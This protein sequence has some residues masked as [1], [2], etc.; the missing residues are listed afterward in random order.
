MHE[1]ISSTYIK[2]SMSTNYHMKMQINLILISDWIRSKTYQ[3][4]R[5][6]YISKLSIV[7]YFNLSHHEK[8]NT[9]DKI[10]QCDLT[11]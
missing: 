2:N 6:T 5:N 8:L 1:V 4:V 10:L 3:T 7:I 9:Y 11:F